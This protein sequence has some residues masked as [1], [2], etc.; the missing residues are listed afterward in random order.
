MGLFKFNVSIT[1]A[2]NPKSQAPR[3]K[4]GGQANYK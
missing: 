3:Q 4:D 1:E 2:L